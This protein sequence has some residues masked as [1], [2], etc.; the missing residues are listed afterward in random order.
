MARSTSSITAAGLMGLESHLLD[1]VDA[2]VMAVDLDGRILFANRYAEAL[3][4]WPREEIVGQL[5]AEFFGVAIDPDAA[6]EIMET[7]S[8]G[9]S[10]EGTFEVRRKDGTMVTVHAIDS[11]LYDAAGQLRGVVSLST[12]ATRERIDQ[13]LARCAVVLGST[14]DFERNLLA[15]AKLLVP[16]LGD[17]CFID[18]RH[19][20]GIR[21]LAAAH[22]DPEKQ[23]LVD[24]LGRSFPPDPNGSHPAVQA[25]NSGESVFVADVS[26]DL[27]RELAHDDEHYRI[28]D[29]LGVCSYM[30][31]PLV[32]RGRTLGAVTVVSCNPDRRFGTDDVDVLTEV[33]RRAALALDNARLYDDQE[34]ARAEAESTAERLEQLQTLATALGR[35]VTVDEVTRVIGAIQMPD[36]RSEHRGLWLLSEQTSSLELVRGFDLSGMADKYRSIPLDSTLPAAEVVRRRAPVLVGSAAERQARYPNLEMPTEQRATFAALPLVAEERTIGVFALGFDGE[37][38]FSDD[39]VRFLTAVAD[40]CAQALARALL[41]D[42]ERLERDRAERDRR[43]INELNRALQSSLLP[44]ALPPIPGVDLE[45]RYHPALAGLEVGGDFYDVFDTGGDYAVV[46]GDVCGKGPEAAA[47]TAVARWT[48][49]SVAMDIRQPSQVLRKVNEALVHQQLD[50]RFCTIAYAR[51]VPTSNGVRVS[52][53]RGGHPAPVVVRFDGAIEPVGTAGSLIGILP[54]VRLWEETTHLQSGDAIVFYTDGVTEARRGRDQFGDERLR[55]TLETCHGDSAADIAD[56]VE[57]AVLDFAGP[58][59][60][61][62]IAV[63]VLRVR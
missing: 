41:Y 26:D 49:R 45:A 1:R 47:V 11:P 53:C 34:R 63:L 10:W 8:G 62:D 27:K 20:G 9:G 55:R 32:A 18:A 42:R 51:V 23:D 29:E 4:G 43:R 25:L 46:I 37:H 36:L 33:A 3:Y 6:R 60:N 2:A 17:V 52:V 28:V 7:L 40:Q 5:T 57:R 12:D 39:D 50:D 38:A 35:A 61:D 56:A 30:C 15:L 58:E 13:F 54:E 24:E 21:R 31:V 19:G 22:A 48:I 16:F 14:L 59:P 44:P